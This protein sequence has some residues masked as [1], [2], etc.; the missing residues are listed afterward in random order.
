LKYIA[1][2]CDRGD[3]FEQRERLLS[4]KWRYAVGAASVAVMAVGAVAVGA[5]AIGALAVGALAIGRLGIGTTR[6]ERLEIEEL[7]VRKLTIIEQLPLRP[8]AESRSEA[9]P[10]NGAGATA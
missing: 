5:R 3:R 7:I 8:D 4:M 2:T 6:L 10:D 1:P 9:N